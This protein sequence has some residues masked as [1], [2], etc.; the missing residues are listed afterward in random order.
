[1]AD[2][3]LIIRNGEIH[4]GVGSPA[5][6][7]DLAVKNGLIAA[8]GRVN[9]TADTVID[10]GGCI[11]TPGFVDIHT[12]FDG[13]CTWENTLAPSS[14]HGVTSIVM[15]N[16]GVGFAPCRPDQHDMLIKLMEGVEDIPEVVLAEGLPWNWETF[17]EYLDR[18]DARSFDVDV[19]AQLP[20]SAIRVYVMG[21][22]ALSGEAANADDM[23]KMRALTKE[24]ME[25]GAMGVTTSRNLIHR[26]KAGELAPSLHSNEA[27]LC[28][29]AGGLRDAG[30]GVFQMIPQIFGEPNAEFDIVHT[31]A[32]ACGRPISFTLAA[33][34]EHRDAWM[35]LPARMEKAARE[36]GLTIRG[37]VALRPIGVLY[38]LDLSFHPFALHPSFKPLADLPLAEKVAALRDPALRAQLLGEKAEHS[39]PVSIQFVEASCKTYRMGNPPQYEPDPRARLDRLAAQAGVPVMDY[40]YDVLLEDEG[41]MILYSPASYENGGLENIR[42]LLGD[43]HTLVGL[44]D[45]G[46]H[47]GLI[48]DS[49]FPTWFLK[50]W[51]RDAEGTDRI[52]LPRAVSELTSKTADAVG[53]LDRGRI[54]VGYKADLNVIDLA[55]LDLKA[56]IV[57]RDLPAGGKRLHQT[58]VGYRYTIKSGV[59]TYR[60]G[61][62]TGALPGRLV[63]GAQPEPVAA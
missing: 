38:G 23:A 25:A 33:L 18:V 26:T 42:T 58:A 16:C 37:Q 41:R 12:H 3:D 53:M 2:Y 59:V 8:V 62:A 32:K 5:I 22:R 10:A 21:E 35:G 48:C 47:Y 45:G 34:G 7:G 54:G 44:S 1:M 27:E 13:Q 50:R 46:A 6:T 24:A 20:H 30:K 29:I 51:A 61:E 36:D 55:K 40:V 19:G 52:D 57:K 11:V 60:D 28:E 56:P 39:N 43:N 17:P 31:I 63:R 49:S 14:V 9:G 4:D 15:G